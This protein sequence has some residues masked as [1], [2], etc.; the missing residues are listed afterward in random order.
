[1]AI[2]P[3]LLGLAVSSIA[4]PATA[5]TVPPAATALAMIQ[6]AQSSTYSLYNTQ[7]LLN[8]LGYDAG[9]ADGLMGSR[10]Q[11]AIM[12]YQRDQ[13]L[14]VTGQPSAELY[15]HM[16]GGGSG[17]A[18]TTVTTTTGT[19]GSTVITSGQTVID[20]QTELRRRGYDIDVITGQWDV[21]T[22]DAV[23]AYQR[24]AGMTPT[25]TIDEALAQSLMSST[26][27]A[28][29]TADQRALVRDIQT[30][31]NARGYNAGPVDGTISPLTQSAIR[32]YEADAGLPV[33]GAASAALLARL[34]GSGTTASVSDKATVRAVQEELITR[35]YLQAKADGQMGAK[36]SAAIREFEQDAGLAVTGTASP[37]LLASLR[38]SDLTWAEANRGQIVAEIEEELRLKGYRVGPVDGQLDAQSEAAIRAFQQ[39]AGVTVDG[40]ATTRLLST[41][42]SSEVAAKPLTREEAVQGLIQGA[43]TRLLENIVPPSQQPTQ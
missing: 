18:T 43:T 13:G 28:A 14:A 11:N 3:L 27:M 8:R 37:A 31:L 9:P 12:A 6:H 30:A 33:T 10:T 16:L 1:M 20:V 2:R 39:D 32:T 41:I 23:L 25:G 22:R 17:G 36:T 15:A 34:E 21:P 5:Q 19:T 29:E 7:D 38:A 35:G 26:T 40:Q 42:R 24:D 4:I